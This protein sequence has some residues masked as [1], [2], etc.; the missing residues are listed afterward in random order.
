MRLPFSSSNSRSDFAR[1]AS[2]INENRSG[3]AGVQLP[4]QGIKDIRHTL[5][6]D[7][8]PSVLEPETPV[9]AEDPSPAFDPVGMN[10]PG[11]LRGVGL[12]GTGH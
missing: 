9:S 2:F 10:K 11:V 6:S 7:C 5:L 8:N 1:F 3:S 12:Q 4:E